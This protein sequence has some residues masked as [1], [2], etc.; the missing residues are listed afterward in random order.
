MTS[1]YRSIV[2][3]GLHRT[4][5]EINVEISRKSHANRQFFLSPACNAPVQ[6]FPFELCTSQRSHETRMMRLSCRRKSFQIDLAVLI[7]YRRV[8][9]SQPPCQPRRRGKDAAH[10]V[11]RVTS[12]VKALNEGQIRWEGSWFQL[13]VWQCITYH[14]CRKLIVE[15]FLPTDEL[16]WDVC[17]IFVHLPRLTA[18]I[19]YTALT[20][21]N[22]YNIKYVI[23]QVT[24]CMPLPAPFIQPW[25]TSFGH[26]YQEITI[27]CILFHKSRCIYSVQFFWKS[28]DHFS[29]HLCKYF[30]Y[31]R[32][33]LYFI[34]TVYE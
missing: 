30:Y 1:Y 9:D 23:T 28:I 29:T 4:V 21:R 32:I 24:Y 2:T 8:T 6:G 22:N 27:L 19:A 33:F 31:S 18:Q 5:S 11:A 25:P 7:Q 26:I 12:I 3:L 16:Q 14:D 13:F 15:V 10:Y 17:D 20:I 34:H